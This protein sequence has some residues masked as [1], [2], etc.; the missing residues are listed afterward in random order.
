M[1]LSSVPLRFAP[2]VSRRIVCAAGEVP[3][4]NA[5]V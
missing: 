3:R 4:E 5:A 1:L 2:G